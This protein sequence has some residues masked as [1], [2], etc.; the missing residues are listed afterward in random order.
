[1]NKRKKFLGQYVVVSSF[2][3]VLLLSLVGGFATQIVKTIQYNKEIAQLKSNIKNVDKEIKDL[4]K[5]KQR[6]DNDKYIEDIARERLKM[7]KSN[8]IIYIDINK[9]SK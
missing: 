1:M 8:E 6:L 4:K 9:G 3:L 7:V 2:L 5:D